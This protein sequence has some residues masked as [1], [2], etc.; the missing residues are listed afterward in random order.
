MASLRAEGKTVVV[1]SGKPGGEAIYAEIVAF[2]EEG[3]EF[4]PLED[5]AFEGGNTENTCA[6]IVA[7]ATNL[8]E[9]LLVRGL[10][11]FWRCVLLGNLRDKE[12]HDPLLRIS[13]PTLRDEFVEL[14]LFRRLWIKH[15]QLRFDLMNN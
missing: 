13:N 10:R 15:P 6:L 9:P 1:S 11:R 7:D 12:L 14:S 2:D 5:I 4:R 3:V 8:M